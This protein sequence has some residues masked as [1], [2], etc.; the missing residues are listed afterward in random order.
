M[1]DLQA[2]GRS[3]PKASRWTRHRC[4]QPGKSRLRLVAGHRAR[5]KIAGSVSGIIVTLMNNENL[6]FEIRIL[7]SVKG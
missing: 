3:A 4:P 7:E 5:K 2:L 6:I 1:P